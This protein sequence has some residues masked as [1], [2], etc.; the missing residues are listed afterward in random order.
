MG[1]IRGRIVEPALGSTRGQ[2]DRFARGVHFV[3]PGTVKLLR[4]DG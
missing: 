4:P 2:E 1:D 3:V